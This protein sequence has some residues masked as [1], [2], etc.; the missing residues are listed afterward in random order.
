MVGWHQRLNGHELGQ[1]LGG[2]GQERLACYS[3]WGC[4]ESNTTWLLKDE[5]IQELPLG[6]AQYLPRSSDP[7][8]SAPV[9]MFKGNDILE[10]YIKFTKVVCTYNLMSGGSL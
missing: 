10:L 8:C 9:A 5:K 7:F 4:E 6:V 2:E 1:T 3:P